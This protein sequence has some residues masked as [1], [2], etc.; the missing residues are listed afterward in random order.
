MSFEI[1]LYNKGLGVHILPDWELTDD[2]ERT[3]SYDDTLQGIDNLL[4]PQC[5]K[6]QHFRKYPLIFKKKVMRQDLRMG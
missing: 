4:L 3:R 1:I 2:W 5:E 6:I